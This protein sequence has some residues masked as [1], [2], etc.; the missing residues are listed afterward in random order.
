MAVSKRTTIERGAEHVRGADG[1]WRRLRFEDLHTDARM[2]ARRLI[3]ARLVRVLPGG[4]RLSGVIVETEAYV[5]VRD[6]ASH[7]FGGRR[8]TRN[9]PMYARAGTAYVYFTY[10]MH[11]CMNVTSGEVGEPAAVLIRALEPVEGRSAMAV[12]RGLS[13]PGEELDWARLGA[14]DL[15][16]GPARLCRAM[17]IDR[18][19]SGCDLT[20]S[21]E[22]F[23]EAS[24]GWPKKRLRL[25]SGPRIG[26]RSA[27]EWTEKPLRWWLRGHPCVSR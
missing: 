4:E 2:L 19:F 14:R 7:A 13:R 27:G 6:R 18:A 8:T 16:G 3:G 17:S 25:A 20:R 11:H 9:E 24:N 1:P 23:L 26:I 21:P 15:C 5:G 22:L 12:L 10:G